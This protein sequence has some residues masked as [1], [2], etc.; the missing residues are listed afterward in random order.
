MTAIS[1]GYRKKHNSVMSW[2]IPSISSIVKFKVKW[3]KKNKSATN[4]KASESV[5]LHHL[6]YVNQAVLPLCCQYNLLD[7]RPSAGNHTP[8]KA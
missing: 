4:F 5:S 6:L 1:L 2:P 7:Y 8:E 3:T